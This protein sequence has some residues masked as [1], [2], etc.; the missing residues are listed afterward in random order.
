MKNA[1]RFYKRGKMSL[2]VVK[3]RLWPNNDIWRRV[4][5]DNEAYLEIRK[6]NMKKLTFNHKSLFFKNITFWAGLYPSVPQQS[7][8]PGLDERLPWQHIYNTVMLA[9]H[10]QELQSE[11]NR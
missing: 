8:F 11:I 9:R 4:T 10:M 7:V 1:G 3:V 2:P 6:K 5:V